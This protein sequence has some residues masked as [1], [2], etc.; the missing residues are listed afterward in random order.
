MKVSCSDRKCSFRHPAL[1]RN[2]LQNKICPWGSTC[3]FDHGEENSC[4]SNILET[5]E[6]RMRKELEKFKALVIEKDYEIQHLKIKI[7]EMTNLDTPESE[8]SDNQSNTSLQFQF[9]GSDAEP[10][11]TDE[12]YSCDQ[13]DKAFKK[14]HGLRVH[15]GRVHKKQTAPK[16]MIGHEYKTGN[17]A[18]DYTMRAQKCEGFECITVSRDVPEEC[19]T[20]PG[21][22][23]EPLADIFLHSIGCWKMLEGTL[24]CPDRPEHPPDD[25]PHAGLVD[26]LGTHILLETDYFDEM[27]SDF[28]IIS[29]FT[30]Q[31]IYDTMDQF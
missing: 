4:E 6:K 8:E 15:F 3:S 2:I 7:V 25:P 30:F 16:V 31:D 23:E 28:P 26:H 12:H 9:F 13:C 29:W 20:K 19:R 27:E 11:E 21:L 5:S 17:K 24:P 22:N 18:S 14:I 10:A 1:C